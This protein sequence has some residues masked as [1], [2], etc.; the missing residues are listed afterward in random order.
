MYLQLAL[1]TEFASL[2]L[3]RLVRLWRLLGGGGAWPPLHLRSVAGR[4]LLGMGS[5]R[6]AAALVAR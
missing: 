1:L 4:G 5:V 2:D 6:V 3:T